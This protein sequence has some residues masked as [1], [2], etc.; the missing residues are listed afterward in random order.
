M[1]PAAG[2][3]LSMLVVVALAG[4]LTPLA[5]L[6][7]GIGCLL[8]AI[9][10]G[11]LAKQTPSAG[12]IYTYVATSLGPA[13]GFVIGWLLILFLSLVGPLIFVAIAFVMGGVLPGVPW[14]AWVLLTAAV[15][16]AI[17]VRDVRVSTNVGLA[18][19]LAELGLF[20]A[21]AVWMVVANAGENTLRVFDPTQAGA[22]GTEGILKGT[23][24]AF[25]A[26]VGFES[27]AVLGE[28]ARRPRWTIPRAVVLS[29]VAVGA[30]Y[31]FASYATVVGFGFDAFTDAA[32]TSGN[33]WIALGERYWGPGWVLILFA[34]INSMIGVANAGVT[35]A[36]RVAFAM[37]RAG[38][39]PRALGR[40]HPAF[41]TPHV[42]IASVTILGATVATLA[43]IAWDL[44]T[45]A[46]VLASAVA[47]PALVIYIVACVATVVTYTRQHRDEFSPWLHAVVP[48]AGIALLTA[49]LVFQY[50][51]FPAPPVSYANWFA[52]GW[53]LAGSAI[54]AWL[55]RTRRETLGRARLLFVED[56]E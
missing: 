31:L 35:A 24:L 27:A 11:Q 16:L 36:S 13:A 4:P 7:A 12:G 5:F 52:L 47:I 41:R 17:N 1:G 56:P 48:I 33:P 6:L 44:L 55:M 20:A 3:A 40:T 2:I 21:L 19:G 34:L 51:P 25:V 54:A 26:F 23:A 37:G 28:E 49:P 10:I 42:A 22:A 14:I 9:C 8:V 50:V 43:G 53:L 38:V 45:A 29:A 39:L 30:F 32:L 46:G 18:L 15:V